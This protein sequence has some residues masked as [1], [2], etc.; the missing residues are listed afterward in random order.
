M[1]E[2][3]HKKSIMNTVSKFWSFLVE[4]AAKILVGVLAI[5]LTTFLAVMFS[6]NS[7]EYISCLLGLSEKSEILKFLGIGMG[8]VLLALQ[9]LA[10]HKRASAMEDSAKAKA[11]EIETTE[12]GQQQER[13]KNAIEHLGHQSVSVRMGGAYELFH[14]A[15]DTQEL[16]KTVLDILCD[17]IRRTTG[18]N[19]YRQTHNSNPSEEIQNL[20]TLLFV[21]EHQ[22]FSGLRANLQGS[23]L[24]G[25]NL[26]RAHLEKA[27][28]AKTHLQKAYLGEAKLQY[29]RLE[30]ANLQ[31][32][33]LI[34][35]QLEGA[36]LGSACLQKAN[37][38]VANLRMADLSKARLQGADLWK[39][40]MR[41]A[42]FD[43][44]YLHGAHLGGGLLQGASFFKAYLQGSVCCGAHMDVAKLLGVNLQGADLGGVYLRGANLRYAKLQGSNLY[45][46][47]M[48]AVDVRDA[49]LN[50]ANS[51]Q[52][53]SSFEENM[54]SSIEENQDLSGV[55]FAGGLSQG[56]VK[57]S[58]E[59]LLADSEETLRDKLAD[60]AK[61]LRDKLAPHIGQPETNQLPEGSQAV[62][63]TY[64]EEEA[65]EW[66]A[67][68]KKAMSDVPDA[69]D[70]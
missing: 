60:H 32:A 20:L 18:E 62:T 57:T 19:E 33:T 69:S 15:Q 47:K 25:A 16:R 40:D 50:G 28:L 13:L 48:Q 31:G 56:D 41:L 37:L 55:V 44:A 63:G 29:A 11:K 35:V 58:V 4:N 1:F 54:R 8:G 34:S 6:E 42:E 23:W 46:S 43:E 10:S 27:L 30:D 59:V 61:T 52:R 5:L 14:L 9:A 45:K 38:L 21:Q 36:F 24:N 67:E 3:S 65:E 39:A 12:Q 22:V 64:T 68:Y 49:E 70:N 2:D 66:I 17:H 26:H 53:S 7:E 51:H